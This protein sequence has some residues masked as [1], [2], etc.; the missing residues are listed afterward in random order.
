MLFADLLSLHLVTSL[1][2]CSCIII[3]VEV[4]F[5]SIILTPIGCGGA[6]EVI[7]SLCGGGVRLLWLDRTGIGGP[8]CEELSKLLQSTHSLEW[9]CIDHNNLSAESVASIITGLSHD[10]SLTYLNISNSHFSTANTLH[11]SSLLREHS[12]CTLTLLELQDCHISGQGAGELAA[13]LYKNSTLQLLNLD[14]NPINVEGASSIS[15]MLQH[16]T[17]LTRLYMCDHL[18]LVAKIL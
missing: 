3:L 2:F 10:N 1:M 15:D 12:K 9:L 14:H 6:V 17:S 18:P 16:N 8:D 13:A 4:L 11:L 5:R 7:K